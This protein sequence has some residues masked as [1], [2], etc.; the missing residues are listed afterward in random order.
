MRES[1]KSEVIISPTRNETI[2]GLECRARVVMP[3]CKTEYFSDGFGLEISLPKEENAR[4]FEDI[5]TQEPQ[6]LIQLTRQYGAVI[7]KGADIKQSSDNNFSFR[8]TSNKNSTIES[9]HFDRNESDARKMPVLVLAQNASDKP[10]PIP[11]LVAPTTLIA[12][13]IKAEMKEVMAKAPSQETTPYYSKCLSMTDQE[14]L[15]SINNGFSLLR[16]SKVIR[17]DLLGLLR[18]VEKKQTGSILSHLW[19]KE[20]GSVL[21]IHTE[22][23]QTPEGLPTC[24]VMHARILDPREVTNP[25]HPLNQE[26]YLERA[27]IYGE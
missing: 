15:D 14:L 12:T 1:L 22:E 3:G 10:R 4:H 11:T 20:K 5:I 17:N 6:R 8:P 19:S 9:W 24:K 26:Y 7:L 27:F 16:N 2:A 18:R 25:N 21:L 13:H 23:E